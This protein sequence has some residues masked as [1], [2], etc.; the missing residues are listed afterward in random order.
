MDEKIKK[1]LEFVDKNNLYPDLRIIQG[2]A[3]PEVYVD[4]KKVIMIEL[5]YKK[6]KNGRVN[7]RV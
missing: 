6:T 2:G 3:D 7:S 1:I 5:E 4:G